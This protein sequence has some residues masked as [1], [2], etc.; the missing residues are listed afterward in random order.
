MPS[1]CKICWVVVAIL[2]AGF[3][4]IV[5]AIFMQVFFW[6][7][8][9]GRFFWLIFMWRWNARL[10]QCE[11]WPY[12]EFTTALLS[13]LEAD[14]D[15]NILL[16]L[17]THQPG[18]RKLAKEANL[19]AAHSCCLDGQIYRVFVSISNQWKPVYFN[20]NTQT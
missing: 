19:K 6:I 7:C 20:P 2:I 3:H 4:K 17:L 13:H 16:T 5:I 14:S 15:P 8:N 11:K 1:L 10:R 12:F 18:Q 9:D